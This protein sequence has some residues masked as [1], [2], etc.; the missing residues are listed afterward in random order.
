[1]DEEQNVVSSS[2]L[3]TLGEAR[4]PTRLGEVLHAE[5]HHVPGGILAE[6]EPPPAGLLELAESVVVRYGDT[7]FPESKLAALP[8]KVV[9]ASHPLAVGRDRTGTIVYLA[10]VAAI[11]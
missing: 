3:E 2:L 7:D 5:H 9:I 8:A 11:A 4:L 1:M 6:L 10:G